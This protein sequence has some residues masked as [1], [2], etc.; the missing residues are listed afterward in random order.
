MTDK[1]VEL[2]I[3]L[4]VYGKVI[5]YQREIA[6]TEMET[7]IS[8]VVQEMEMRV[9]KAG[10]KGLD[11]ELRKVVPAGW[12]NVGTEERGIMSSVGRIRSQSHW[13]QDCSP[14]AGQASTSTRFYGGI[15]GIEAEH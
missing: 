2:S 15:P 6:I 4:K 9:L 5:E 1:A 11:D 8:Q 7:G 13:E 10:L 12:R 14:R 3:T